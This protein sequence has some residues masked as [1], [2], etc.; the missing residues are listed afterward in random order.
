MPLIT[1]IVDPTRPYVRVQVNWIDYPTVEFARVVRTVVAT[2]ESEYLRPYIGYDGDYLGLVC[3]TGIFWD[4]EAP[5]DTA[6]IY[7]TE[8]LDG[9]CL[10]NPVTCLPCLPVTAS[11]GSTTV[12]SNG[13]FYLGDPVRPCR[14]Q[15]VA[16]CIVNPVNPDCIPTQGIFFSA[17]GDEAMQPNSVTINPFNAENPVA[18]T[19]QRR[20]INS[21]LTLVSRTFADRDA[22]RLLLKPGSPVLWRGPADYGIA[23]TYMDV[24]TPNYARGV[25]D[26]KVQ[27]RVIDLP[28]V[29]VSWFAGP[30]TGVCGTR[31][32]DLCDTYATWTAMTAAGL[33]WEALLDGF[34]SDPGA[35]RVWNDVLADFASWNAVN[36]GGRTWNGVEAG[37]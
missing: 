30:A 26:H 14:D 27:P 16:L 19:R 12:P 29:T 4:T 24:G 7:T 21:D 35:G 6:L 33:I 13:N 3:S 15:T 10:A 2:G 34:G 8:A 32:T 36:T 1:A 28:F 5:L 18:V 22:V 20:G 31:F 17:M 23:D 37:L 25:S 9:P 11:T